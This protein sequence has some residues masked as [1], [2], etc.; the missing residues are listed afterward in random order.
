MIVLQRNRTHMAGIA[1]LQHTAK[2]KMLWLYVRLVGPS[3]R[4]RLLLFQTADSWVHTTYVESFV[5]LL[6][7]VRKTCR[8]SMVPGRILPKSVHDFGRF[9]YLT[10]PGCSRDGHINCGEDTILYYD[11]ASGLVVCTAMEVLFCNGRTNRGTFL[12]ATHFPAFHG[13]GRYLLGI[14][15]IYIICCKESMY[16]VK[17]P[18]DF[19]RCCK[20]SMFAYKC[21]ILLGE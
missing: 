8:P 15:S 5:A 21:T 20:I 10:A 11:A 3:R 14:I 13:S 19:D 4:C 1:C 12:M 18:E 17:R 16:I 2:W 6:L 7:H 9:S